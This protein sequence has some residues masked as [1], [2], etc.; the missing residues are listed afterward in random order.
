MK[1]GLAELVFVLDTS[2]SMAGL[3]EDAVG[4]FNFM[5]E[6]QKKEEGEALVTTVLFNSNS[7]TVHDRLPVG[8]V[9]ALTKEDYAVGGSTAL[10]DAV[11]SAVE[12]TALIH[13]YAREEDVPERTMFAIMTDGMENASTRYRYENVKRLIE[14][15]KAKGWEFIFLAANID[16]AA[17]GGR[18]GIRP[19]RTAR[20]CNDGAGQ[21]VNF[22][23]VSCAMSNY[24]MDG[25]VRADWSE[26]ISL[27]REQTEKK[28]EASE[29]AEKRSLH[30]DL[31][32]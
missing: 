12:R 25:A 20:F 17:V 31:E 23:A 28:N 4:G 2:G 27:Y 11:G 16:A 21:R 24:R 26:R 9:P 10:L 15:S 6:R 32:K 1:R 18:M 7:V 5:L 8:R 13:R 19:E 29:H 14:E 22:D 30:S 3:E